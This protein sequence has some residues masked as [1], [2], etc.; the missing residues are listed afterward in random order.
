MK[1]FRGFSDV[2]TWAAS[3]KRTYE[4]R[5]GDEVVATLR[6]PNGFGS[7]ALGETAE[8][9]IVIERSGLLR[10]RLVALDDLATPSA[11]PDA[12]ALSQRAPLLTLELDVG[13]RGAAQTR[14]GKKLDWVP[15]NLWRT[16]WA[17][18]AAG[19]PLITLQTEGAL[20]FSHKVQVAPDDASPELGALLLLA[21]AVGVYLT[22][23]AA[24]FGL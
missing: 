15:R 1:S 24:I 13:G 23:D 5:G 17:F 14:S 10:P 7:P 12:V 2:M 8:G 22:E 20:K 6:W 4:L 11:D 3:G 21:S 16:A 19:R 18:E 9:K